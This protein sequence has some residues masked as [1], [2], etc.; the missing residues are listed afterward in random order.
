[1][2]ARHPIEPLPI[3]GVVLGPY[4]QRAVP[5]TAEV[6]GLWRWSREFLPVLEATGDQD[7]FTL[8]VAAQREQFE[9][10]S[11]E[12]FQ[13]I[14]DYLRKL[15]FNEGCEHGPQAQALA[16]VGEVARRVL[17]WVPFPTQII[18]ARLLLQNRL[19][20]MH[21]GEGKTF[22]IAL[23]ASVAAMA[24]IPVH[25]IT[26]NEYLVA[27]DAELFKSLYARLGLT[28]GTVLHAHDATA[29]RQAYACDITY[30][31]AKEL[32]FDYLKDGLLRGQTKHD[33]QHRV[34]E[35]TSMDGQA[36]QPLLRGLCMAIVDEADS[37]LID[38]AGTP[39]ILARATHSPG[40]IAELQQA[41]RIARNLRSPRHYTIA[42]D[43][44]ELTAEALGILSKLAPSGNAVWQDAR[45]REERVTQA[46]HALHC[47][48]RDR[49]YVLQ[50]GKI[51]IIDQTTGRL[52]EG[53]AWSRGL[54][55]LLEL[56]EGCTPTGRQEA[57]AQITFQRFFPRYLRLSGTS[58]TLAEARRELRADYRLRVSQVPLLAASKRTDRGL[59]VVADEATKWRQVVMRVTE[60]RAAGRPVLIGTDSV[61][62]SERL[63]HHLAQAGI[64]HR[65][66]NARQDQIEAEI[67]A[68]AGGAGRVTVATNMAGRGT[69]I[70]LGQGVAERGGLHVINCQL[71]AEARI[72]RQLHGRA[73]RQGEPGSCETVLC[74]DEPL[75]AKRLPG[76]LRGLMRAAVDSGGV[77]PQWLAILTTRWAQ[78]HEEMARRA[79][80]RDLLRSDASNE[81]R[82]TLSGH[83]D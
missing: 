35:L 38:E 31:T 77:L 46:L 14:V 42:A 45:R 9:P 68:G 4:P 12:S 3:P 65:V 6:E 26:A 10:L 7:S 82:L 43:Q 72:D 36:P 29:R 30:V 75:M 13:L 33:L 17:G 57:M 78:G 1:M 50:E 51:C 76:T 49:H 55:Q 19:A 58:A 67:V 83:R 73:A 15:L 60:L 2:F 64:D 21:T 79:A 27:R 16:C 62:A 40:E 34:G 63:S 48:Q 54:H 80:R 39:L 28:V 24:G 81:R 69:D 47:L 37:V 41:L 25:C 8:A 70:A 23:A 71:N 59:R 11:D 32:A 61:S 44:V 53:R 74:L 52:A 22:A 18:A 20:E 66:L 5:G 56:K